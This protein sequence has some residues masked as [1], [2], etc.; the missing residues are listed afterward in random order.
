MARELPVTVWP[1]VLQT[2]LSAGRQAAALALARLGG[3]RRG[4]SCSG[5]HGDLSLPPTCRE[6]VRARWFTC[7]LLRPVV[8]V[9]VHMNGAHP[10]TR[11][12]PG[13]A[14]ASGA[15]PPLHASVCTPTLENKYHTACGRRKEEPVYSFF[16][17]KNLCR[18]RLWKFIPFISVNLFKNIN[19]FCRKLRQACKNNI[20]HFANG[21][22]F[23]IELKGFFLN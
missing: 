15:P 19:T 21:Y 4:R 11:Q 10:S 17:H 7:V 1:P 3:R 9:F 20:S 16:M 6:S 2:A 22:Y 18:P 14:Q 5:C 23:S 8:L 12:G 13:C